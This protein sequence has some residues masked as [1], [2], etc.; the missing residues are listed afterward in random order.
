MEKG[1]LVGELNKLGMMWK[2]E[3]EFTEGKPAVTVLALSNDSF[4]LLR[5]I[6]K[7]ESQLT[8]LDNKFL[9]E[10]SPAQPHP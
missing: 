4:K 6:R 5:S 7:Q 8:N 9:N 2:T 3:K 1:K 10:E